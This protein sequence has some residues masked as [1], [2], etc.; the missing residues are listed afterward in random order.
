MKKFR[1]LNVPKII[2]RSGKGP[3]RTIKDVVRSQRKKL[4]KQD[5][6]EEINQREISY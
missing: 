4:W 6:K 3:H 2:L 1:D 5:F